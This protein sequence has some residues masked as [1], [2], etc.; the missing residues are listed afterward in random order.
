MFVI[1]C[2]DV[3]YLWLLVFVCLGFL[4]VSFGYF[5]WICGCVTC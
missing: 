2:F 1:G 5:V 3:C 4:V